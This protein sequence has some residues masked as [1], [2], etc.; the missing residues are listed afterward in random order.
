MYLNTDFLAQ[1]FE[2]GLQEIFYDHCAHHM[3]R[4]PTKMTKLACGASELEGP[5]RWD[6][7]IISRHCV[8]TTLFAHNAT[9]R[10][11]IAYI[12]PR[13]SCDCSD[14]T[15]LTYCS[16][17]LSYFNRFGIMA[18]FPGTHSLSTL[19]GFVYPTRCSTHL[20]PTETASHSS[21]PVNTS[22]DETIPRMT[23]KAGTTSQQAQTGASQ[24][25]SPTRANTP[26][27]APGQVINPTKTWHASASGHPSITSILSTTLTP[28]HSSTPSNS[29]VGDSNVPSTTS[30]PTVSSPAL[31]DHTSTKV[32]FAFL[33]AVLL[34][35]A[36]LCVFFFGLP[37]YREHRVTRRAHKVAQV[38]QRQWRDWIKIDP[39][40][41]WFATLGR[42]M[43]LPEVQQPT[44]ISSTSSTVLQDDS[45]RSPP[46]E[47]RPTTA[48]SWPLRSRLSSTAPAG[49]PPPG[50]LASPYFRSASPSPQHDPMHSYETY[51]NDISQVYTRPDLRGDLNRS[52]A[53]VI[54]VE[55]AKVLHMR[56]VSPDEVKITKS[57]V[58]PVSLVASIGGYTEDGFEEVNFT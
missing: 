38:V 13:S 58:R 40:K 2:L 47:S 37:K 53:V 9:Y 36:G 50:S 21:R 24:T 48:A 1:C 20:H 49:L 31:T 14:Q 29:L 28:T 5:T 15:F 44:R 3:C 11:S 12:R 25:Q 26:T 51:R 7:I 32:G 19:S 52:S 46:R 41:P 33:G 55:D 34:I 17:Q 22:L 43:E 30:A 23:H 4:K 35:V 45:V 10:V 18:P 56:S 54:G 16:S 39:E 8:A 42:G 57:G 27:S 6:S